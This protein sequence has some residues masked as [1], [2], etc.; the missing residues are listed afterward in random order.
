MASGCSGGSLHADGEDEEAF[1][2]CL[3]AEQAPEGSALPAVL[4]LRHADRAPDADAVT[5]APPWSGPI[6][7]VPGAHAAGAHL[8]PAQL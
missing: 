8:T 7:L 4:K 1:M 6:M 2:E 3:V 5:V